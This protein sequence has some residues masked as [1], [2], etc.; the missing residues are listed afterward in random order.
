M[1]NQEKFATPENIA[2][3]WQSTKKITPKAM[4]VQEVLD[5]LGDDNSGGAAG[6]IPLR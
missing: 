1:A 6:L 4:T 5:I 3:L 2:E